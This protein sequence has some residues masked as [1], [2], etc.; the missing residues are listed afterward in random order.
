MVFG[1]RLDAA[2]STATA[3]ITASSEQIARA[4]GVVAVVAVA[5]LLLGLAALV[6]A[7]RGRRPAHG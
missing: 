5:A 1:K 4:I 6:L 2:V 7:V 3:R